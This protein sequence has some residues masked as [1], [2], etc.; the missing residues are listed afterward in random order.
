MSGFNSASEGNFDRVFITDSEIIDR[1]VGEQLWTWGSNANGQ[2]GTGDTSSY[3]SPVTTIAGGTN[4]KQV[5]GDRNH[6][7][8]IKTDGTL[9]T[10][11][12]N[13]SGQLGDGTTSSRLSP[14]TTA[15]GGTNWKQIACGHAHTAAI[16]TDGTLWACGYNGSGQLGDGTIANKSSPVTT[17]GGGTNW[18]QVAG[19]LYQTVAIKTDGTLWAW[20]S[21]NNGQ[22]GDGTTVSKRSP[23]TTA[24]GGTNWKQVAGGTYHTA[25][26]KTDGT[27]WT[28][29]SNSSGQ[30]GDGTIANKSSPV[31][32]AG[33]GTNWKQVACG[34]YHTAAIAQ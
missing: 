30:L 27:L 33:G 29:G 31:T 1:F 6:T 28:W 23:I 10:W 17:S 20:G 24:G 14:A 12:S 15:G 2:L 18:K 26:I 9:W 34:L 3:S 5:E 32:T 22:L 19:G 13:S 4:W 25:A 16:K 11:G 21:N 7:A 8:A